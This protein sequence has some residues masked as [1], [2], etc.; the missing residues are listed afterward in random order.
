[1]QGVQ[2]VQEVRKVQKVQGARRAVAAPRGR[3]GVL[4]LRVLGVPI[5]RG[6]A[7]RSRAPRAQAGTL[8]EPQRF[9]KM[10]IPSLGAGIV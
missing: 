7:R 2:G 4:V 10:S 5:R 6:L 3:R 8:T 9:G 1:M